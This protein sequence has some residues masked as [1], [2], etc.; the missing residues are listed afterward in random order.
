MHE[1]KKKKKKKQKNYWNITG[2]H[3]VH[4]H[5]Q[6]KLSLMQGL[7]LISKTGGGIQ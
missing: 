5:T 6:K 1:K 3:S 4:T 7:Y 2:E